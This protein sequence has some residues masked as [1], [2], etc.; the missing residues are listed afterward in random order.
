MAITAE[1]QARVDRFVADERGALL[2][3]AARLVAAP[4]PNPPGDERQAAAVAA[5]AL[6][7]L[8]FDDVAVVGPRPERA[9]VLCRVRT[10]RPGRTLILNGHLDTKPPLPLDAWTSDPYTPVFRDGRL[11]GLGAAD[12][13][14]PDAALIYGLAAAVRASARLGGEALLVLNADEEGAVATEGALYLNRELGITGDGVLIAEPCG[15]TRPWE[16]IPLISRGITCVRFVV[17]GT[18]T[19]SSISDR[20]PVVNASLEAARLLLF[21]EQRLALTHAP[22]PLCP[23]GPTVNLGAT[24][25]G[26]QGVAVVSGQAEF[27]ADIRTLPGM[28]QAQVAEDIER[29]LAA[30]RRERPRVSVAWSFYPDKRS[31]T[32][33]TYT[34]PADPLVGAVQ[35]AAEAVLGQA[36]PLGYFPGGTD[37]IWWQAA[38]GIPTI[39]GFGPGLLSNCHQPN[40]WIAVDELLQAARIAAL[41]VI[42]YLSEGGA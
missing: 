29:A 17:T 25:A 18:Q 28:S 24:L 36:P 33:P 5:E 21:L 3:L 26:G 41:T 27:S 32:Q 23:G 6:E 13:K 40:E 16:S 15:V 12:M 31:W 38:A 42:G 10:G 19:H 9:N 22:I 11:I 35:A 30:F 14:G 37:A 39:P 1:E 2:D 4:S 7:W 20:V 34:D 8:G